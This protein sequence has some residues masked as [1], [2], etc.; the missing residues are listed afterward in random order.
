MRLKFHFKPTEIIKFLMIL[1]SC[2][3]TILTNYTW[4]RYLMLACIVLIFGFHVVHNGTRY[5]FIFGKLPVTIALFA[6]YTFISSIWAE[7]ASDSTTMA[8]TLIE[9]LMMTWILYNFYH[10]K[11]NSVSDILS[12]VKWSSYVIVIYSILHYGIEDLIMMAAAETRLENTYANVNTI[13]MLAAIGILIQIDEILYE[14]KWKSNALLCLPSLFMLAMTQ[15]RKAFVTVLVGTIL[16]LIMRNTNTKDF[17]RNIVNV[18]AGL[19]V[20]TVLL[21]V[22]FSLPIFS[23]MLYRME[24][25]LGSLIGTARVD[26]STYM[27]N[28]MI[29]IGWEQFLKSPLIGMGI[30]NPHLLSAARLGKDAY[31]HNN[32]I[33]LLAGG[34]IIGFSIYYSMYVYLIANFW[35]YRKYKNREYVICFVIMIVLLMMDWGMVSYYQKMRYVYLLLYFLEVETLKKNVFC[36]KAE[37]IKDSEQHYKENHKILM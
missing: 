4:G 15:S 6:V 3:F 37:M 29:H 23:G 28:E 21:Y 11:D 22:I 31:L 12:I 19:V 1:L 30:N 8:R 32:F 33:E 24:R 13:G 34:G 2:S 20:G 14:K 36:M 9:L 27:R 35:K 5:R 7:K 10:G 16:C 18:L 17:R 26:S 25:W